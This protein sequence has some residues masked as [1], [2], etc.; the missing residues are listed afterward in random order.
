MKNKILIILIGIILGGY[1][2][3]IIGGTFLGSLNI[4][5]NLNI[6]GYE[7]TTYI[8]SIIVFIISLVYIAVKKKK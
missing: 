6:E 3:L 2:G 7:L 4:Y 5:E 1:I 8:G